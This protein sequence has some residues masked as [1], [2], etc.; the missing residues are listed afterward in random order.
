VVTGLLTVYLLACG[1]R[2]LTRPMPALRSATAAAHRAA[3]K[4]PYGHL[5][6]GA[7]ALGTAVMLLMP[8]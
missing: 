2:S 4:D 6:D 1:M 5:R 7:M 3:A 8:H